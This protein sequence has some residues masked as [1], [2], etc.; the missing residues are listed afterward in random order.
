MINKTIEYDDARGAVVRM[1]VITEQ[2]EHDEYTTMA[3]YCK[4]QITSKWP[5]V[6]QNGPVYGGRAKD[7][8]FDRIPGDQLL[9]GRASRSLSQDLIFEQRAGCRYRPTLNSKEHWAGWSDT[10]ITLG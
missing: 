2:E 7:A 9:S 6:K 4:E 10:A 1:E 3:V 5:D 8:Q